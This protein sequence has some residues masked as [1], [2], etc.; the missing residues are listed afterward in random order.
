MHLFVSLMQSVLMSSSLRHNKTTSTQIKLKTLITEQRN[1]SKAW[2]SM[3]GKPE[4]TS[5]IWRYLEL[6]KYS[7]H[8][9]KLYWLR[10]LT[11]RS[12]DPNND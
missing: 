9:D 10:A 8:K 5:H 7:A 6:D 3:E 11:S 1:I 12:A 2:A 4:Q